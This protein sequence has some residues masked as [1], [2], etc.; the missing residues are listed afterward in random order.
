[1]D[2]RAFIAMEFMDGA[3][4]K[5][6]IGGRPLALEPLLRIA[7]D[8]ADVTIL[9]RKGDAIGHRTISLSGRQLYLESPSAMALSIS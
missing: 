9:S 8:I 6:L 1:M 2:G 5:H 4:L 3:T 7:M